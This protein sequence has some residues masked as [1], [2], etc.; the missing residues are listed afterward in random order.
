M[1]NMKK[2][3]LILFSAL[4]FT[5]CEDV[6]DVDL[7]EGKPQLTVDAILTNLDE[8]QFVR[9]TLS[10]NYFDASSVT[11]ITN[12]LVELT[13]SDGNNYTFK[14]PDE[15][16]KYELDSQ[17]DSL[18]VGREYYLKVTYNN[19]VFTSKSVVR[20]VPAI[21]SITW[22]RENIPFG[23]VDSIW[24]VQFWAYD[25]PGLG[26]A[27]WVKATRNGVVKIS[28]QSITVAY[29]GS[30]GRGAKTDNIPF[31]LPIR[32]SI[33]P[34]GFAGPPDGEEFVEVG[35]TVG[36]Q[37]FSISLD[38]AEYLTILQDQLN[39]GGLFAKPP[40]NLPTNISNQNSNGSKAL[41][42]FEVSNVSTDS[43]E[44]SWERS[45]NRK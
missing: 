22:S 23:D 29:D 39:N 21:D 17:F 19:E 30:T 20:Q 31:I 26:D 43:G 37:L 36:V 4:L 33:T 44:I 12:A 35:E 10:G 28:P 13:D 32:A 42:W 11:P 14:S 38:F 16:G 34:G 27:Y 25:N 1:T 40:T 3:I 18:V 45:N 8:P 7:E 9:L 5:S 2:L 6:I 15:N 41:G 24:A